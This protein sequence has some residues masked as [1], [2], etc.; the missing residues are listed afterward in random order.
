MPNKSNAGKQARIALKKLSAL[1]LYKGD[2]RKKPTKYGLK[3][4]EHFSD[5]L[6]GKATVVTP[7]SPERFKNIFE[8]VGDK[9]IVPRRK[10]EKI[11]VDKKTREIVSRRKVGNRTVEARG[12]Q[13]RR[14]Q[15]PPK[16]EYSATY[17]VPLKAVGGD[18]NWH[19]FPDRQM[20]IN[21]M[22]TYDFLGWENYVVEERVVEIDD[23]ELSE[24]LENMRAGGRIKGNVKWTAAERDEIRKNY[25]DLIS[26]QRYKNKR[27]RMTGNPNKTKGRK[28]ANR[29]RRSRKT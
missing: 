7:K 14:G 12:M 5:V 25:R 13:I 17:A 28:K 27:K 6:K 8:V 9:V 2:L 29:A 1:G 22:S 10:G 19:R 26:T 23:D 21:F 24:R 15:V 11:T 3:R 20:L 16:T 4:I 18:I